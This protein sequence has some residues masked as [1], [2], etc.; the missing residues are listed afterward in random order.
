MK[1]KIHEIISKLEALAPLSFQE[2]YDNAGLIVGRQEDEVDA[3]LLTLDVTEEVIDEA[4]SSGAGLI[5]A[6]HPVIFKGLKQLNGKNYVERCVIKAIKNDV[7]IYASHTN[8]D[9]VPGGVNSKMCEKLGLKECCI[10][11]PMKG[12]LLKLVTFVPVEQAGIV[13]EA[14]FAAGAGHIGN[15][16]QC[17]FN[18]PGEGTFRGSENTKPFVGEPGKQHTEKEARVETILPRYRKGKVLSALL[19][20]HPYE[21]VAYDFYPLENDWAETGMGMVGHLPEPMDE[22]SFLLKVKETFRC[23]AVRHTRLLGKPVKKVA[24]CGG[25][26]SFLLN[27]AKASGADVFITGDFKYHQFFDAGDQLV[28]ADIGHYES[29]QFT[30]EVFYEI[31]TENF[32]NFAIRLSEVKTNPVM[33]L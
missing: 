19:E 22:K 17:S 1:F 13:R 6:H 3:V 29:E 27:E 4:I 11:S 32:P 23:G 16:D 8:L 25:S 7:A 14:I 10:L 24:L 21:E 2:P 20:S 12:Q 5:I 28:I 18:L 9:S 26:G 30:K 31:L 33:Y 15:Y